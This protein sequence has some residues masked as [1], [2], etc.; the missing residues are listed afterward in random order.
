MPSSNTAL[1]FRNEGAWNQI[2]AVGG[3]PST[4]QSFLA[5]IEGLVRC[6][7]SPSGNVQVI[8]ASETNGTNVTVRAGSVLLYRTI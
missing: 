6:G 1:L 2:T 4:A 8:L 3:L 5:R 7:A